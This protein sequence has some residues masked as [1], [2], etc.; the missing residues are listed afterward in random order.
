MKTSYKHLSLRPLFCLCLVFISV[1]VPTQK[2]F[3]FQDQAGSQAKSDS[4]ANLVKLYVSVSDKNGDFISKLNYYDFEVICDKA[5][6]Q[7]SY[8]AKKDEPV[9]IVLLL[10]MSGS[11]RNMLSMPSSHRPIGFERGWKGTYQKLIDSIPLFI[12][13]SHQSNEYSVILF[14]EQA[15]MAVGWTRDKRELEQALNSVTATMPVGQT[16]L[17][18]SLIAAIEQAKGSSYGKRAVILLTDGVD[19]T[20]KTER[21][22]LN[23][24]LLENDIPVY[25]VSLNHDLFSL[26][27]H[28]SST[29]LQKKAAEQFFTDLALMTG[30]TSFFPIN[31][32]ELTLCLDKI[33]KE[34]RNQYLIGFKPTC[35]HKADKSH[36]VKVRLSEKTNVAAMSKTIS[37][38]HR[39]EYKI[40]LVPSHSK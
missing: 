29:D 27:N 30:G 6:Q 32:K 40:S 16:S 8:F 7:V 15:W 9:G 26:K 17:Y 35:N 22:K 18:D 14:N 19:S 4:N 28:F 12:E 10:D 37:I 5:L 24:V 23:R 36:R 20:S 38:R 3:A 25:S 39:E 33:A 31:E 2:K 13:N 1:F 34:L 11:M 21:S